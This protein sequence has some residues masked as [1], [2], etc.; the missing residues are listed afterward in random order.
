MLPR[1]RPEGHS[2][3]AVRIVPGMTDTNK[4]PKENPEQ[5]AA[6]GRNAEQNQPAE[7]EKHLDKTIADSFPSSD[8]PSTIPNPA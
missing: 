8:P 3:A 2:Y 5:R 6:E 7:R 1:N 4:L